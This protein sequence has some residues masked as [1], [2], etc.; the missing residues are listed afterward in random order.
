VATFQTEPKTLYRND[1]KEMYTEMSGPLGIAAGTTG[2]IAWTAR[3]F[4]YDNDG[5]L[6]ILFTNGHT[7]DNVKQIQPDKTYAQPMQLYRNE[8]GKLFREI[9]AEAGPAFAQPIVGRGAAFG[10]YDDD[11]KTDVLVMD[12]E[13]A[14]LL[15]HNEEKSGNHWLRITLVGTRC[16][17][18]AIGA[19][20]LVTAGG[21][22]TLRDLQLCGGYIS[23]HD[24]R[25]LFG[26][27]KAAKVEKI[28]V[29]WPDGNVTTLADVPNV[30]TRLA[31]ME[32]KARNNLIIGK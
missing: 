28:V 15:L 1:G 5:W 17:R 27:G 22:T 10:D 30:D 16:N 9:N 2:Y 4:D 31:I 8:Q 7:Q 23:A 24:P 29:R 26:L 25:L 12:E 6:D 21:K 3:F 14:P 18:D 19:R 13:G 20:V 32:G 11:G